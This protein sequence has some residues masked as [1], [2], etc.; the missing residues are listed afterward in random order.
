[1]IFIRNSNT[2]DLV[3]NINNIKSEYMHLKE[4]LSKPFSKIN[5]KNALSMFIS[6]HSKGAYT[7]AH[8]G[9][10]WYSK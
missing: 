6:K 5:S 4:Q 10:L 1:M 8:R 2:N 3:K 9:F 7:K